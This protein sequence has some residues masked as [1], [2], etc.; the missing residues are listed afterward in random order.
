MQLPWPWSELLT[1][2][3]YPSTW[4]RH[5]G[6]EQR[7]RVV[8]DVHNK[9]CELKVLGSNEFVPGPLP[10]AE[11]KPV[12]VTGAGL[13][14]MTDSSPR[15]FLFAAAETPSLNWTDA[16]LVPFVY[17]QPPADGIYDFLLVARQ[18][19]EQPEAYGAVQA[20]LP[21]YWI[22]DDFKARLHPGGLIATRVTRA[23]SNP[24]LALA[25]NR[26]KRLRTDQSVRHA[27]RFIISHA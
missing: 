4:G 9:R 1:S 16:A 24:N 6:P 27:V 20:S 11:L 13:V 18:P 25:S 26:E 7:A 22:P 2:L 8:Q 17:N 23:D 19:P 14:K 3:D 5:L 12:M 15:A 10:T 21:L